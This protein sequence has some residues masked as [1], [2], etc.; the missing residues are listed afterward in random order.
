MS[1]TTVPGSSLRVLTRQEVGN[2]LRAKPF[3]FGAA[4]TLALSVVTLLDLTDD[5][6]SSGA[7]MI[8]PGALLGVLGV[9]VMFGLARR[10][11]HVA[12]AAGAVAVPERVRTLALAAATVVPLAV[13]LVGFVAAVV[14]WNVHPPEGYVVPPGVSDAFVYAQMFGA[15]VLCAVGGPLLGLLLARYYPKR[16]AAAVTSVLLVTVTILLQGGLLGTQPYRVFWFWT[17]FLTQ[18]SSGDPGTRHF[19]TLPGNPYL[20]VL[21]LVTLCVLGVVLAVLHD[22]EA[23]RARLRRL[24]LGVLLVALAL[25]ALTMTVGFTEGIV[26]PDVCPVC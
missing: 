11:D 15:G 5:P 19:L 6:T 25:G 10:S 17:Y 23:D 20:W 9:G 22:P 18:E 3:W 13:A 1:T 16:G 2:Y 26:S 24:A 4:L 14:A 12:A 7:Y 21:Y 8:V